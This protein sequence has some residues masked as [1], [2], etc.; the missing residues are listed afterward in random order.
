[1]KLLKKVLGVLIVALAI[2]QINVVCANAAKFELKSFEIVT[3]EL[4]EDEVLKFKFD[5]TGEVEK[6]RVRMVSQ[7]G[8]VV[9]MLPDVETG[10]FD[11]YTEYYGGPRFRLGL[12]AIIFELKDGSTVSYSSMCE[13][14]GTPYCRNM[15]SLANES[16]YIKYRPFEDKFSEYFNIKLGKAIA[17]AGEAVQVDIET[18]RTGTSTRS[19]FELANIVLR[20]TETSTKEEFDAFVDNG[21]FIVPSTVKPGTYRIT[22]CAANYT[23][24]KSTVWPNGSA[25]WG[26]IWC[27]G[28]VEVTESVLN[29]SSYAFNNSDYDKHIEATL[30]QLDNDAEITVNANNSP[31]ISKTLFEKIQTTNRLLV[32]D[33]QGIRW[34]FYGTDIQEPKTIDASATLGTLPKEYQETFKSSDLSKAVLLDFAN[35]GELPGRALVR[36]SNK[37]LKNFIETDTLHIYHYDESEKTVSRVATNVEGSNGYFEFYINHNSKYILSAIEMVDEEEMQIGED[38]MYLDNKKKVE[39]NRP[40]EDKT[41]LFIVLGI[42]AAVFLAAIMIPYILANKEKKKE[43][44]ILASKQATQDQGF[45]DTAASEKDDEEGEGYIESMK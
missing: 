18:E 24:G 22:Y 10:E 29:T 3:K 21:S 43:E 11:L 41:T 2:C 14:A 8:Q 36:V 5:Y 28:S 34:T 39:E 40:A 32:I 31:I 26:S 25:Q 33:Y 37:E 13:Y 9:D 6:I 19:T 15:D 20:L 23:D 45:Y 35:K 30:G 44:E 1:M 7:Y 16:V 17:N 4:Y 42:G 27:E 38:P 12:R